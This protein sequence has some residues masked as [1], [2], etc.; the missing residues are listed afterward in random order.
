MQLANLT[1]II[2]NKGYYFTPHVIKEKIYI[3]Y[4]N[5]KYKEKIFTDI[6]PKYFDVVI[7]GMYQVYEGEHG[8]TRWYKIKDLQICGK[9]GTAENPHGDNHSVFI[10]FAPKDDPKIAV[11]VVIENSGFGSTWA[12]PIATLMIEKYL[13]G[14]VKPNWFEEK[15]LNANLISKN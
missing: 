1:A 12:A 14:S 3:N 13:N 10:A 8:T 2:A 5:K 11:A 7:E 6:D 9:T 4:D 15:M